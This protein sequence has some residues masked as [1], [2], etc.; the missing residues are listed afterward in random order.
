MTDQSMQPPL[1]GR[2]GAW[3]YC[4]SASNTDFSGVRIRSTSLPVPR[5]QAERILDAY[6]NRRLVFAP[7]GGR[8]CG[9]TALPR[10]ELLDHRHPRGRHASALH[11]PDE[12]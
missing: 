12:G 4:R 2:P 5:R 7:A 11:E 9:V 1:E 8:V 3:T 6:G 10:G